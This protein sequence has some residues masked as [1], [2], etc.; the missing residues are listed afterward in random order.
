MISHQRKTSPTSRVFA[1]NRQKLG[2]PR[3]DRPSR[4]G[5]QAGKKSKDF[6]TGVCWMLLLAGLAVLGT[7]IIVPAWLNCQQLAVQQLELTEQ[8]AQL[9]ISNNHYQEAIEAARHDAAFNERLLIEGLNYRRPGEQALLVA[10]GPQTH[11]ATPVTRLRSTVP[12]WVWL[13]AFAE[14]NTRNVLMIM[15]TGLVFFAFIY[16]RPKSRGSQTKPSSQ[17]PVHPAA[18]EYST[19][20]S[21]HHASW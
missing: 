16:Y 15:S 10:S 11:L 1:A 13:R 2:S 6:S 4:A 8:L 7:C 14:H 17:I 12:K 21:G 19:A 20:A 5:R 18:A 9:H 3:A